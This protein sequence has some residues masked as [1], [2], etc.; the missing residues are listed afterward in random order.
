MN[1][2]LPLQAADSTAYAAC[3][4]PNRSAASAAADATPA[5]SADTPTAL[6]TDSSCPNS[7]EFVDTL[8]S[9]ASAVFTAAS[10]CC[11][12][13]AGGALAPS[14]CKP[15]KAAAMMAA[16]SFDR[17]QREVFEGKMAACVSDKQQKHWPCV[18][19]PV[20]LPLSWKKQATWDSMHGSSQGVVQTV[21]RYHSLQ[22]QLTSCAKHCAAATATAESGCVHKSMKHMS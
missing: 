20:S 9:A 15:C 4:L 13:A 19:C 3:V 1:M 18:R 12:S 16:P 14:R 10:S 11:C 2:K 7:A 22:Q 6:N 21:I 8:G 5:S 17:S